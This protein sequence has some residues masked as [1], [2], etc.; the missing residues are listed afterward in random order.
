MRCKRGL[1]AKLKKEWTLEKMG[2]VLI[3]VDETALRAPEISPRRKRRPGLCHLIYRS[4]S[5]GAM[6]LQS[7]HTLHP[8][9]QNICETSQRYPCDQNITSDVKRTECCLCSTAQGQPSRKEWLDR[10]GTG[11]S[12]V[13]GERRGSVAVKII[14]QP[15]IYARGIRVRVRQVSVRRRIF[16]TR[17]YPGPVARVQGWKMRERDQARDSRTKN[18]Q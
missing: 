5:Q 17:E 16:R 1:K 13:L 3:M 12:R 15:L 7:V 18:D 4:P 9:M 2:V 10:L 11:G 14:A 8:Q 6:H